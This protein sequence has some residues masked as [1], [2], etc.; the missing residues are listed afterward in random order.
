MSDGSFRR[1]SASTVTREPIRLLKATSHGW[2]DFS[3]VVSGGGA[4][5]CIVVMQFNGRQYPS[6]PAMLPCATPGAL[7]WSISVKLTASLMPV[8]PPMPHAPAGSA[9]LH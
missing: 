7:H 1:V 6:N 2:H 8:A 3:V 9:P 5:P 4:R